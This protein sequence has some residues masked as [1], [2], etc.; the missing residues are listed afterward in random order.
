MIGKSTDDWYTRECRLRNMQLRDDDVLV[1]RCWCLAA[2]TEKETWQ[3]WLIYYCMPMNH[4]PFTVS[5]QS[6]VSS[7]RMRGCPDRRTLRLSETN[8]SICRTRLGLTR[9]NYLASEL[10]WVAASRSDNMIIVTWCAN[11]NQHHRT[12]CWLVAIAASES[13]PMVWRHH[14]VTTAITDGK[15]YRLV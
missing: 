6:I 9:T 10:Q 8:L 12:A 1:F 5:M 3:L 4:S 11:C 13:A 15:F 2:E 7:V 14:P